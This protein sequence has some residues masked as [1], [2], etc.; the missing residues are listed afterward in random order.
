MGHKVNP[1]GFRLGIIKPWESKWYAERHFVSYLQEDLK[2]RK[3]IKSMYP[4]AGVSLVEIDRQA[5]NIALTIHTARPGI[6]IGRGGQRVEEMR[7]NLEKLVGKKIQLNIRE[8]QQPEFDAYLV[9]KSVAESMERRVSYRRALKQALQRSIQAGAKGMRI[10]AA[11]RLDGAEIARRV[12]MHEG[13]VP[14]HTIRADIDYGF[15][16]A[17]T[18]MGRIGIKVW[19]YKGEVL[20][21]KEEARLAEATQPVIIPSLEVK[22]VE[23]AEEKPPTPEA[24]VAEK[25]VKRAAKKPRKPAEEKAPE[26]EVAASTAEEASAAKPAPKK[27][28]K[29]TATK[30]EEPVAEAKTEEKPKKAAAKKTTTRTKSVVKTKTT[31]SKKSPSAEVAE[32]GTEEP[33][34]D[35]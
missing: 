17:K 20:P 7:G 10:R 5:N 28:R 15:T 33:S 11:G 22:S 30:T 29:T 3:A 35:K 34:V 9:A 31:K 18:V 13:R 8:V 12:T 32:S 4:E 23:A 16:E 26:A 19:I 14:L 1:I 21:E 27:S 24:T 6:L 25:P 2:I